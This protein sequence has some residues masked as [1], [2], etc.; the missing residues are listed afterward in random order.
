[1]ELIKKISRFNT[2][3]SQIGIRGT[4]FTVTVDE[5]GRSLVILLP[6]IDGISSGEI[7]VET[8]AGLVVLNKPYESTTTSVWESSPTQPVTLDITLDLIDNMLIVNE[9]RRRRSIEK[10]QTM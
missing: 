9:P 6:D 3:T 7:T 8:A 2:P 1:M 5:L 10:K 4:D